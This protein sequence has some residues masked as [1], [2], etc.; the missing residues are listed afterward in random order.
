MKLIGKI[1]VYLI[2]AEL[3]NISASCIQLLRFAC[4]P[5]DNGRLLRSGLAF[6][7]L[8][9]QTYCFCFSGFYCGVKGAITVDYAA[10][11]MT[12]SEILPYTSSGPSPCG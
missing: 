6:P 1:L 4:R 7:F 12:D 11:C 8:L 10:R 5:M 9:R 2:W 3:G